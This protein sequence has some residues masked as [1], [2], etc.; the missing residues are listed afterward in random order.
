M[1]CEDCR[2]AISARMDGEDA[3]VAP[4]AVDDH[5]AGCAGCRAFADRAAHVTRLARLRPAEDLP[6]VLPGVPG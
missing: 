2:D 6:D 1:R 4:G 5:L 3:G